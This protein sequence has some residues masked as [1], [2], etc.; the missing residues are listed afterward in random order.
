MEYNVFIR[1]IQYL[2]ILQI[3]SLFSFKML[4][5]VQKQKLPSLDVTKIW[6]W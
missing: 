1:W 2:F 3:N 4:M 6:K 5:K